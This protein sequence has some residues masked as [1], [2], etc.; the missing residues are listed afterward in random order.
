MPGMNGL[1]LQQRLIA[2]RQSVPI[3]FITGFPNGDVQRRA[4]SAGAQCFLTKPYTEQSLISNIE[5]ALQ[6]HS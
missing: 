3:I 4:L 2:E 5:T 6:R 1:A